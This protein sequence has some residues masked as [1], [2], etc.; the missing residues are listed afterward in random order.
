MIAHIEEM[1]KKQIPLTPLDRDKINSLFLL[2]KE[3]KKAQE[4][5]RQA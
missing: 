4:N 2:A 1:A 5:E 3:E